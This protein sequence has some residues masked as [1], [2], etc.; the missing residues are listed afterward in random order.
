M[1]DFVK[2]YWIEAAF[3]LLLSIFG[4]GFRYLQKRLK[5]EKE[6]LRA[7]REEQNL[8]KAGITALL[9]DRLYSLH[10]EAYEKGYI[11]VD[12]LK[13]ATNIYTQYHALGGNG[14]GT[15]LYERIKKLPREKSEV[16]S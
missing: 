10:S 15:D 11:S 12:G 5:K 1:I 14:V 8:L 3:T 13:N 2:K 4:G 16:E 7:E 9:W 6:A